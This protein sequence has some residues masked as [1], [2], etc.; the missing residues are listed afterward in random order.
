MKHGISLGIRSASHAL[1]LVLS[2]IVAR[3]SRPLK[4]VREYRLIS[5]FKL[6]DSTY[7]RT[8]LGQRLPRWQDPLVHYLTA[9]AESRGEPHPLF[10]QGY[11]LG[12]GVMKKTEKQSPLAHFLLTGSRKGFDPHPLFDPSFYS[13]NYPDVAEAGITAALHFF[14]FG[15]Q[16]GRRCHVLFDSNYYT[17]QDSNIPRGGSKPLLHF[18][19]KGW[20][21]KRNPH[22]LF[23][24]SFYLDQHPHLEEE[25]INPLVHYL[26]NP[27]APK[28]DPHPLFDTNFYIAQCPD[29]VQHKLNPLIHFL[30]KGG[31]SGFSP[32]NK[33]DSAYYLRV[34]PTV[35]LHAVNPLVH[36]LTRGMI[37]GR[38]PLNDV[39][40]TWIKKNEKLID[41][42]RIQPKIA[43][44]A[45]QPLISI[46]MP[47]Y[48]GEVI[49]LR[50]AIE[51]VLQQTY[52]HWEL[53]IADDCSTKPG[54]KETISGFAQSDPRIKA[55]FRPTTGH[56]ATASNSALELASGKFIALMDHDDEI[57][58]SAL[59]EVATALN[60]HPDTD[61]IYSDED[62]ITTEGERFDP[63]FKPD[64]APD[65]L[66]SHM[67][68]GHLSV[69]RTAM[70]QELGGFRP[71]YD[72]S[73][74]YDLT[75]RF[76]EKTQKIQHIS[77]ILYHWRTIDES[78]S[79]GNE[80][81]SYAYRAAERAIQSAL[82]RRK[83]G[84]I[85]ESI[86]PKFPGQYRVRYP[87]KSDPDVTV[88]LTLGQP[89]G[90][91]SR[92]DTLIR[93][94]ADF[95]QY[96]GFRPLVIASRRDADQL[97]TM[98]GAK[99]LNLVTDSPADFSTLVNAGAVAADSEIILIID[100]RLKILNPERLD[101][102]VARALQP[103]TGAVGPMLLS[104]DGRVHGA[105]LIMR[106][107]LPPMHSHTQHTIESAGY[108][109]HLLIASNC[110][111]I[112]S[113]CLMTRR[114]LFLQVGGFDPKLN[115]TWA[116]ADY[117]LK[118]SKQGL[119]HTIFTDLRAQFAEPLPH[120][121]SL[122]TNPDAIKIM[123]KRWFESMNNDPF[124]SPHLSR[125]KGWYTLDNFDVDRY[126]PHIY[127]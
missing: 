31:I 118:L 13:N 11:Y 60:L 82:E 30:D 84:A 73:Q 53:C 114:K 71:G 55:V 17:N 90:S 63:F 3:P 86:S 126:L 28:V 59:Y 52:P 56:I 1:K 72:G 94:A 127:K 83:T 15:L 32:S 96:K 45:I 36:F 61:L 117:C 19:Q 66:L 2:F 89:D 93:L 8:Q 5:Y 78:T 50:K 9:R 107:D 116:S 14:K 67:Y 54:I 74:D 27:L 122:K 47:T 111:A 4:L 18:L 88:L 48:N 100:S 70:V 6:F 34:H 79:S 49:W 108:C 68:C 10:D 57:S 97:S 26:K 42:S 119:Y 62:K 38:Y 35:K 40:Q 113:D 44:L 7:Y 29:V 120:D 58:V 81:K 101:E 80:V 12:H 125:S 109:G 43:S 85:V 64:W 123:Q 23:D 121:L 76:T 95:S 103:N 102:M 112:S 20:L 21:E 39:Y 110:S 77:K 22:L 51:S 65:T 24:T 115:Q 46:L 41:A 69:Y 124:Y 99:N 75:L 37:E 91:S 33:F 106:G 92:F 87:L 25:G 104:H 16:E 105:G 98:P